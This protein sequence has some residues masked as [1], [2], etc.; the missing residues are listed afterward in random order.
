MSPKSIIRL[1]ISAGLITAAIL[2]C[3]GCKSGSKQ[4][5]PS[6]VEAWAY[7]PESLAVHPLSRFG[8]PVGNEHAKEIFVHIE[9][10]DGDGFPCRAVGELVLAISG[11]SIR[12]TVKSVDLADATTNRKRFDGI[13]RTYLVRFNEIPVDLTNVRVSAMFTRNDGKKMRATS[14][15]EK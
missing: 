6:L 13:T 7:A 15:I 11:S 10:Q 2:V 5:G 3:S 12:D 14:T 9:F 1:A 8:V 4:V